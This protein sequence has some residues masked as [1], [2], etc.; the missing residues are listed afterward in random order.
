MFA[1]IDET[2]HTGSNLFD[3]QQPNFYYGVLN[4]RVDFDLIYAA[5]VRRLATSIGVA[6]LHANELGSE[7]VEAIAPRLLQLLRRADCR[8]D[9][10][11]INKPDL[12]VMKLFDTVF[13]PAENVAVPW[14]AYNMVALRNVL[15]LKLAAI[16]G[17]D[18]LKKFWDALLD[19]NAGRSRAMIV[20]A[21]RILAG[22]VPRIPDQRSRQILGDGFAWAMQHPE[23]LQYHSTSRTHIKGHMPNAIAFSDMLRTIHMRSTAWGR[24]VSVIRVDQQTQFNEIQEFLHSVHRD[25]APDNVNLPVGFDPVSLR[26]APG[27]RFEV[28]RGSDSVGIQVVDVLL[29]IV[30]Q[31]DRGML[32]GPASQGLVTQFGS[33]MRLYELSLR[34][35]ERWTTQAVERIEQTQMTEDAKAKAVELMAMWERRRQE[36]MASYTAS[37][38]PNDVAPPSV[39]QC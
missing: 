9:L 30:H 37:V 27:S 29:W 31:L 28:C 2:G 39:P 13:D 10:S 35:I 25:A 16:A 38:A 24:A 1:Y 32:P 15:L 6:E 21:L 19:R 17:E 23:V 12:A 22:K 5:H 36:A 4:S 33:R 20:E 7:K 11:K 8:F 34:H 26:L 3:Q 14:Q 18:E